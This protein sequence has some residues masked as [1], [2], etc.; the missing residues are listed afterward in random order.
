MDVFLL[1]S[2]SD[3]AANVP[4]EA[5]SLGLPVVA[6]DVGGVAETFLPEKTGILLTRNPTPEQVANAVLRVLGDPDFANRVATMRRLLS[7]NGST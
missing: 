7:D 5:Q 2:A 3:A 6:T 1:T 4:M